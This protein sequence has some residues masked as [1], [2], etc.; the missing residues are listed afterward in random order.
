[1]VEADD[2]D[3]LLATRLRDAMGLQPQATLRQRLQ[4]VL[5]D[6][7]ELLDT[8]GQG[9]SGI[10]FK[11]KDQKLGR[12]VA[13]KCLV[14]SADGA[15]GVR[16]DERLFAAIAHEA[17]GL[18]TINH[19]A[20]ASVYTIGTRPDLPYIV[21]EYVDGIPLTEAMPSGSITQQ[22][23]L[24]RQA[25]AGIAE[26]HRHGLVHRDLKPANILVDRRGKVK[27]VDFGIA[28]ALTDRS[29]NSMLAPQR[30]EGSPAYVAPEQSLGQPIRPSADVF[31]LGVILFELLTGHRPF[32]GQNESQI[33]RAIRETDPPLPRSLREDIP[34]ALQAICL[35]ALEKDPARRY[36]TARQ[37]LLDLE[38]FGRGEAVSADPTLLISVLEHGIERHIGDVQRWQKDRLISTRECDYFL[39]RYDRLRQREDFWVLDSRRISFSQVILHLGVWA[40]VVSAFLMLAFAWPQLGA[41]RSLLPA[42]LLAALSMSGLLLWRL[43]TPRVAIVLLIGATMVCPIAVATTLAS[44]GFL[45]A[46]DSK[47]DLLDGILTNWQLLAAM[48]TGLAM[49]ILLCRHTR[50]VAFSLISGLMFILTATALF[51]VLGLR[52]QLDA[53]R[54]DTVAGWYFGPGMIILAIAM[55]WDLRR[56]MS[57][58]AAPLYVLSVGLLLGVVTLIA[59]FGPTLCWL[60]WVERSVG[61]SLSRQVQYSFMANGVLYLI[62][63][64][65]A[66]RSTNSASLRRIGTLLFWLAPSHILI[67]VLR[68]ENQWPLMGSWTAAEILLPLIALGF[69]FASVPRQMKSFF[70][71]GLFYI[72]IAVQRVTA[73]H[74]EDNTMWPVTLGGLGAVLIVIAWRYPTLL[75]RRK[76]NA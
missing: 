8:L 36:P 28:S 33:I 30:A 17:R 15:E 31:S 55:V 7:Y 13:I 73:R 10:V 50:T 45:A 20:V 23:E 65:L 3:E 72:A 59:A 27:L 68:L 62:A 5:C 18:S 63:G 51:G 21:M 64:F 60:G 53:G 2:N 25:L 19:E 39:N 42:G 48:L 1:M 67:P 32:A 70:F 66:S 71:S 14:Q 56:R 35:T 34:G 76:S 24:F 61:E 4:A 38:R 12:L 44:G 47:W 43:R 52:Q 49:S 6:E 9:G 22:L 40:C 11:A 46:A 69:A 74:L 41:G 29:A 37:F 57:S 58:F 26:L 54:V 75:D 16:T